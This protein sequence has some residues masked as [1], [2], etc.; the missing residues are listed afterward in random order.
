VSWARIAIARPGKRFGVRVSALALRDGHV[1]LHRSELDDFWSPAGGGCELLEPTEVAL[2][3]EMREEMG[4]DVR[5]LRLLWVVEHFF[6]N[7]GTA[8][9]EIGFIYL[10]DVGD[11]HAPHVRP[12]FMGI[13]GPLDLFFRWFRLDELETVRIYPTFLP[14][15]LRNL[16]Q[17]VR[18]I[19]HRHAT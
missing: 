5:V 6:H 17:T 1:L 13:E 3:R 19:V 7:S 12:E 2:R 9:H 18:H 11:D 16:P 14:G 4:I 10:V 8:N 15:A